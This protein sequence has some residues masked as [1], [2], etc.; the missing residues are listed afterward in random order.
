MLRFLVRLLS[1]VWLVCV[2][3][4]LECFLLSVMNVCKILLCMIG[5]IVF[6]LNDLSVVVLML[7]MLCKRVWLILIVFCF[8]VRVLKS[9]FW[10]GSVGGMF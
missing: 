2:R 10:F 9:L 3:M 5:M 1:S 4:L 7:L 8:L 6:D